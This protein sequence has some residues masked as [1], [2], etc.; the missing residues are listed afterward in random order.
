VENKVK[1]EEPQKELAKV[2]FK[3]PIGTKRQAFIL[4]DLR[5]PAKISLKPDGSPF[6]NSS[7]R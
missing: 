4:P 5:Y 1:K 6:D 2:V 3:G 7:D